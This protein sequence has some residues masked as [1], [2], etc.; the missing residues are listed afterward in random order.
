MSGT[1]DFLVWVQQNGG[2]RRSDLVDEVRSRLGIAVADVYR[3]WA[4]GFGVHIAPERAAGLTED[5]EVRRVVADEPGRPAPYWPSTAPNVV[6]GSYLVWMAEGSDPV[7]LTRQL[8]IRPT[9]LFRISFTGFSAN[10]TDEQRELVRRSP[11]VRVVLDNAVH[12]V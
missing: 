7:G 10:L 5:A 9:G 8:D 11:G 3:T 2:P 1:G 6:A 12:G 4:D